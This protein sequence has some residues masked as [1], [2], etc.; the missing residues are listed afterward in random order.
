MKLIKTLCT[1]LLVLTISI[2]IPSSNLF[3]DENNYPIMPIGQTIPMSGSCRKSY[4]GYYVDYSIS[5]TYERNTSSITNV[6]VNVWNAVM[7]D[8]GGAQDGSYSVRYDS[9]WYKSSVSGKK[10]SI[11]I[12]IKVNIISGGS[13]ISTETQS[14]TFNFS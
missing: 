7:N 11:T 4:N 8:N 10:L 3:A 14:H 12:Y 9:S 6:K 13:V 5:G 1:S 2:I